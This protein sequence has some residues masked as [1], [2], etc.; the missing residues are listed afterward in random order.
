M[1]VSQNENQISRNSSE[2]QQKEK[3]FSYHKDPESH[4]M[5]GDL[6]TTGL[7]HPLS[8]Q[9]LDVSCVLCQDDVTLQ[10]R[11]LTRPIQV[12]VPWTGSVARWK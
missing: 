11:A 12:C 6:N 8:F 5:T 2:V 10:V 1:C 7:K 9:C 4:V 3:H